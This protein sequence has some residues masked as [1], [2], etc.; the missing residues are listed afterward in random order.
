MSEV[1]LHKKEFG[2]FTVSTYTRTA[3][4]PRGTWWTRINGSLEDHLPSAM[5]SSESIQSSSKHLWGVLVVTLFFN[6]NMVR[7]ISNSNNLK[8]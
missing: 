4:E 6:N 5:T 1:D 7:K 8:Q 3:L 2:I